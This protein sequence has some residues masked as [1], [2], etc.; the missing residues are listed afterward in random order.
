MAVRF[1]TAIPLF[2]ESRNS[3]TTAVSWLTLIGCGSTF[4]GAFEFA[5]RCAGR[6]VAT[7]QEIK[8]QVALAVLWCHTL[9]CLRSSAT[10][11]WKIGHR[12]QIGSF[13]TIKTLD[14]YR[15]YFVT[16]VIRFVSESNIISSYTL[17]E[18]KCRYLLKQFNSWH[19]QSLF[20]QFHTF[21]D[22]F[23]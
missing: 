1:L 11:L 20:R 19:L 21:I 3:A 4:K 12:G 14:N 2:C 8:F 23:L 17:N 7:V 9:V 13:Q 22:G 6:T 5:Q 18:R 16:S 15:K 10:V